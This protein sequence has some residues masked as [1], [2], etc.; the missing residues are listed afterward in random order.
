MVF[1]STH[2]FKKT[3]EI[4]NVSR[5]VLRRPYFL[6]VVPQNKMKNFFTTKRLCRAGIIA[7][8]YVALT[9]AFGALAYSGFLEIRPAEALTILPLFFPEAVPALWIGCM[10]ANLG[11]QFIMYDV[12]I[13]GLATL[14][15]AL[16]TYGAGR[17]IKNNILKVAVGGIFPVLINAFI[18][19]F[20]IIL[21]GGAE[22]YDSAM[23]AYWVYF[24]SLC[25]TET[26]WVYGLG[27]PLFIAIYNL[28]KKGVSVFLDGS[29]KIKE[30][31]S[32]ETQS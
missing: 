11:S 2:P 19:P 27:I 29:P 28:R 7:A 15:A 22:G 21:C 4:W 14:V 24:G 10:L 3:E 20:V 23:I 1:G 8:L 9:Y 17:L 26:L 31:Q 13:G 5:T 12:P 25:A 16:C 18:I 6:A 32:E 30:E